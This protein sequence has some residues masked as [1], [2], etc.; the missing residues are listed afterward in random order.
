M[1][2]YP[3]GT[4]FASAQSFPPFSTFG[5]GCVFASGC[6]FENP[7]E[8]D[9]GCI[10]DKNCQLLETDPRRPPHKTGKGCVFN[11]GAVIQYTNIG[12]ANVIRNPAEYSPVS[13]GDGTVVGDG[14]N[15]AEGSCDIKSV[16]PTRQGQVISDCKVSKDWADASN[17]SGFVGGGVVKDTEWGIG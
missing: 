2:S 12:A 8:F 11:D 13:Q 15:T 16:V 14:N 7:C 10:F 1:A 5:K 3:E 6:S 9:E 17:P 4:V